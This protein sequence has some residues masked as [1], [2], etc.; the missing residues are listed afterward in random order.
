M[1]NYLKYLNYDTNKSVLTLNYF[2]IYIFTHKYGS[3]S[4][5]II[6]S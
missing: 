6:L 1:L 4:L 3:N 5:N 2:Y